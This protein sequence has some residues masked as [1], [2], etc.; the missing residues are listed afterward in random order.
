MKRIELL[1]CD[2]CGAEVDSTTLET[3]YHEDDDNMEM[4][5]CRTCYASE[6]REVYLELHMR[7]IDEAERMADRFYNN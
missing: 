5:V 7:R 3:V 2:H 6:L 4:I 1:P